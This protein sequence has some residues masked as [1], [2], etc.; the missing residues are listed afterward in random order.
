MAAVLDLSIESLQLRLAECDQKIIYLEEQLNW[1][2]RQL[3]GKRSERIVSDVHQNQLQF[4]GFVNTQP[5]N[6][7]A[8]MV[9]AHQRKKPERKGQDKIQLPADL[10]VETTILDL[11]EK[12]KVCKETGVALVK[13]GEEVSY[14]L[15]FRPAVYYLKEIIRPKYIH[16][17]KE[18]AGVRTALMPDSIF[19]K[20]RAD[21]S[22]LAEIAVKKFADHLPLY[23]I[24]EILKRDEIFISRKLL[25]QWIIRL[26]HM[27]LPL[28]EL[29]KCKILESGNVYIDE[30][31]VKILGSPKM[32]QGYMWVIVGGHGAN[33]PYRIYDFKNDRR[34]EHVREILGDYQGVLHSDKY[35]AYEVFTQKNK[36]TWCPCW[37]HIRRKF[38]EAEAGDREL[39]KWV[40]S[41][42][43]KLFLLEESAWLKSEGDR[44]KIRE[45]QEIPI[46]DALIDR[47]KKKLIEGKILPKSK[48]SDALGYFC[49][50]IP[51]IKNY[52]L[53][54]HAR[55][56][57]NVAER[58]IRPLTIGRKNWLFFG[59]AESGQSGGVLL[60]LVQTCR[61]LNINP[62]DYLED[63]FRR[64]MGHKM[65]NL[66]ELLPDQWQQTR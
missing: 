17:Q 25:S 57:N 14:K 51:Y 41:Q 8:Q 66:G 27:L 22:L 29:M 60:S 64:L 40:L 36:I 45:A 43:Q 38:F 62:R 5:K 56:D 12:D 21:E 11:P 13:I 33:P 6:F 46:I 47:L 16:P 37:A 10:P 18:E 4:E 7:Q 1:F 9:P 52:A 35:G 63:V 34:H 20:C 54:P 42:I 53:Y 28:Y 39:R 55:L 3:F 31:P 65:Q 30:S 32:K 59:C 15:A 2:K 61:G 23:R 24:A 58:A 26:G 44:L 19:P 50:L 49:S 48:F